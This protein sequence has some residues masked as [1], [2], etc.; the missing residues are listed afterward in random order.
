MIKGEIIA[1]RINMHRKFK[2]HNE[3]NST[4]KRIIKVTSTEVISP[5]R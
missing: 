3:Q 1:L 5:F 4:I 2:E